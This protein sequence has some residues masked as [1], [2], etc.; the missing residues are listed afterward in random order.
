MAERG[1]PERDWF[2]EDD[3]ELTSPGDKNQRLSDLLTGVWNAK[4]IVSI[5]RIEIGRSKGWEI[6]YR[7]AR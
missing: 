1:V 4:D 3:E 5:R 2:E 6:T 7:T